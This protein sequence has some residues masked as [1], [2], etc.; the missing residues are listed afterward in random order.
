MTNE[1]KLITALCD[2][3][4][5]DVKAVLVD[6][7]YPYTHPA[8]NYRLNKSVDSKANYSG[9]P[10]KFIDDNL[11]KAKGST[12]F[13]IPLE[14]LTKEELMCCVVFN[15]DESK[16]KRAAANNKNDLDLASSAFDPQR[17]YEYK[18]TTPIVKVETVDEPFT[19]LKE[20]DEIF[21]TEMFGEVRIGRSTEYETRIDTKKNG[22]MLT[23]NFVG[24][25][26]SITSMIKVIDNMYSARVRA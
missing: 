26:I 10:K 15:W 11:K 12:M 7:P 1:M 23:T 20:S 19:K 18:L 9:I 17:G 2:A 24:N 3:L 16:K 22:P 13:D 8:Y 21:N 6:N 5:F 14:D 4:G 25:N